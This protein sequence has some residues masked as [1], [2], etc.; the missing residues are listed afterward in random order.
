MN[1]L[2]II[3]TIAMFFA[4]FVPGIDAQVS[5][6]GAYTLNQAVIANGGATGTNGSYK[7]EGT[8]GQPFAGTFAYVSPYS[9][10][11]GFWA[12]DPFAPTA[13]GVS[14]G[15][16]V[17]GIGGEGLRNVSVV[18]SGGMLLTPRATRTNT[19]G[20]FAFDDIAVGE[21]YTVT[22]QH[23]KYGFAQDSQIISLLDNVNDLIFQASWEN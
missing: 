22:V 7:I 14:V 5:S 1:K 4:L 13:A 15:G 10:R 12:P 23:K 20:Y 18:L 8:A 2:S 16:R 11:G 3:G 9:V 19:F 17:V 6:G 21:T